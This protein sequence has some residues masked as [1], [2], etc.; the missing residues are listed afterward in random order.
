M[1]FIDEEYTRYPFY[2]VERMTATLRQK[3][4]GGQSQMN[5]ASDGVNGDRGALPA[6]ESDQTGNIF[7]TISEGKHPPDRSGFVN[8]YY[9]DLA[10][11]RFH[12]SRSDNG[13]V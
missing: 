12:L 9:V 2:W 4:Q 1:R 5:T 8:E 7:I 10:E 3:A 13:L 11:P 6:T